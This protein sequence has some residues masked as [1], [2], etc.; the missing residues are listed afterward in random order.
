ML[1]KMKST[2]MMRKMAAVSTNTL[3]L[4]CCCFVTSTV[5]LDRCDHYAQAGQAFSLPLK[6]KAYKNASHSLK[7]LHKDSVI[8]YQKPGKFFIGSER[9]ID[10]H[11]SLKLTNLMKGSRETYTSE[12]YNSDGAQIHTDNVLLCVLDK[13]S[14]PAVTLSC[15]K[16]TVSF[17]CKVAQAQDVTFK[18]IQN[19]KVVKETEKTLTRTLKQLTAESSFICNV[20]NPVS[21]ELSEPV[22]STCDS[23]SNHGSKIPEKLFGFD[24]WTMVGILAGGGGLILLLIVITI[25]CCNR[26]RRKRHKHLKDEEELRLNF[27]PEQQ[28]QQQQ[29]RHHHH[30]HQ[31]QPAGHT[32]PRQHRAKPARDPE[33]PKGSDTTGTHPRHPR[34]SPRTPGQ[35]S[36]P[37]D[38]GGEEQPPPLPQPRKKAPKT[39]RAR[40]NVN[41]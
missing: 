39:P 4:L 14:K 21:H 41:A 11:G 19:G 34:P 23:Q 2:V 6:Y 3:L 29:H 25:I 26:A 37:G 12:I 5:S 30:H 15:V 7:W 20:S 35:G 22:K 24:F 36:R 28:Q 27:S 9:H 32:G 16:S 1:L 8:V 10:Q 18:W 17:S 33:H 31:Q 38:E 13:V 40:N